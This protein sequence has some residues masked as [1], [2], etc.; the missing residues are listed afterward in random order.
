MDRSARKLFTGLAA[1]TVLAAAMV[2]PVAAQSTG[3]A[4]AA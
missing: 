4:P 1:A 2:G 3:P